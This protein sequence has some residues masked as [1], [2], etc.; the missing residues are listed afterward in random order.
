[1]YFQPIFSLMEYWKGKY[2]TYLIAIL[3]LNVYLVY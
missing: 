2:D 3:N 1:M